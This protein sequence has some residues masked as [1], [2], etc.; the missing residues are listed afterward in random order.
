VTQGGNRTLA[1]RLVLEDRVEAGR[2]HVEAG[3]IHAIERDPQEA[4]GPLIGPGMVDIHVHGWGGH[5]AMDGHAALDGMAR[6]LLQQGVTGFLPTAVTAPIDVLERFANDV[7]DW[8]SEAPADGARP[9][10]FNLEGPFISTVKKGAQNPAFILE[11]S[12]ADRNRLSGLLE[13]LRVITIAPEVSGALDLISWFAEHGVVVSLGHSNATA[14]QAA[15]GYAAGAKSTTHLFN[16]M[17]GVEQHAP[18]LA[19]TALTHDAAYV[20]LVADGFHVDPAV[21]PII[22]RT[23]PTNRLMLVSDAISLA[24]TGEGRSTLGGLEVEVHDGQC[25]L[26]SNGALAGSVIAVD[27]GVRQLVAAGVPLPT[28]MGAASHQPL[29]VLGIE[30]RGRIAPGQWADLVEL[31]DDLRVLRVMLE[32]NWVVP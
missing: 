13:G 1:G 8:M 14:A 27:T 5:D 26:V 19:V 22:L 10:G 24:G 4:G 17:S 2:I 18:G 30:D 16:A 7:R 6:S 12:R 15:L 28:A 29:E 23:K 11:P 31:D 25:R 9:L 21:W 3:R 32:G 20:E